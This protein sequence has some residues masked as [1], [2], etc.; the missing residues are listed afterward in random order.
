LRPT[1]FPGDHEMAGYA[2]K[3][4]FARAGEWEFRA[5]TAAELDD[6]VPGDGD[7]FTVEDGSLRNP[8]SRARRPRL[9]SAANAR[10]TYTEV[11][12]Q[13]KKLALGFAAILMFLSV[14]GAAPKNQTF[15]GEI[16]DSHCAS[17]CSHEEMMQSHENI[18]T[19][20]ECTLA[21]MKNGGKFVLFNALTKVVYQLNDQNKLAQFAGARV[22][23]TG[24]LGDSKKTIHVANIN[25]SPVES[26]FPASDLPH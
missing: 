10:N 26:P 24:T 4:G 8:T 18:N 17:T 22:T 1:D 13:M 14:A 7:N 15:T 21:C 9:R 11:N 2:C 16:M 19:A 6:D 5:F 23:V 12:P 3:R 20:K 25:L